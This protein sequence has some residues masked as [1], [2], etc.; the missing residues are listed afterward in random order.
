MNLYGPGS[1]SRS[2]STGYVNDNDSGKNKMKFNGR[3]VWVKILNDSAYPVESSRKV[4][5]GFA[6]VPLWL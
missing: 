6:A 5:T 2:V 4:H 3:V 1:S